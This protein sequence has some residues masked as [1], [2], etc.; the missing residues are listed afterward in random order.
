M[1]FCNGFSRALVLS[2]NRLKDR[3]DSHCDSAFVIAIAKMGFDFV[4][5][6]IERGDVGQRAFQAVP[7]LDKHFAVLNEHEKDD[8][9]ATFLLTNAPRL[10]DTLRVICDLGVALHLREDG[11]HDLVRC[12]A[13]KLCKLLV[14]TQGSFL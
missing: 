7:D 11:D 14:K 3:I 1:F 5:G 8:A 2:P 4:F 9:I 6:D 12:F 13:F 10:S